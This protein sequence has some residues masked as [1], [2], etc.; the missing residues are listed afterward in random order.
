MNLSEFDFELPDDRIAQYPAAERDASR[1]LVL[2]RAEDRTVH[3]FFRDILDHLDAGDVL[4][5]NNT[6]VIPARLRGKKPSG[7]EVE[8]LVLR[9][10][11]SGTWKA[12]VKGVS[13]GEVLL[14][15]GMRVQVT[16][17]EGMIAEIA[18]DSAPN[19]PDHTA[20]LDRM[21]EVPLPPYIR[22]RPVPSDTLRYQT[23]YARHAGSVA[24]PTAGLHFTESLL[25]QAVSRG[26]EVAKLTLHVGYG[27]FRPVAAE[28]IQDHSM[29]REDY[30]IPEETARAVNR[31]LSDG[32]RVVAVGTTVTRALE[33]SAAGG[34]AGKI[35]PGP[36]S[37][38]IFIHPGYRFR[39][40]KGLLTNFHLPRSSPLMMASAFAGLAMLRTAYK[41]ALDRGYR[42]YSYG[43]AMLI[44]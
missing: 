17:S 27:T 14:E 16:R 35:K 21:G 11:R 24:A 34:N 43:D 19:G 8:I 2:Q 44:L 20:C 42:F 6:R 1:L 40:V 38:E 3:A 30:A 22:R 36:G 32:R 25:D 26:I 39:A 18:F 29:D 23:V 9:Q 28:N 7:G 41:D 37:A 12:L 13:S 31:A 4:V 15:N 10:C 5:L 33:A